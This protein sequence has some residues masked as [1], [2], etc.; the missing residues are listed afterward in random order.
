MMDDGEVFDTTAAELHA[1]ELELE[2]SKRPQKRNRT[3]EAA[4]GAG[5]ADDGGEGVYADVDAAVDSW[6]VRRVPRKLCRRGACDT[7]RLCFAPVC[8]QNKGVWRERER[9]RGCLPLFFTRGCDRAK[10]LRGY[11]FRLPPTLPPTSVCCSWSRQRPELPALNPV[12]DSIAFQWLN[13]DVCGGEPLKANPAPGRGIAGS[14]NG[15]VPILHLFGVTGAGNS[16]LCRVHGFTP[17]MYFQPPTGFTRDHLPGLKAAL[18]H[19]VE[20][21]EEYELRALP[22]SCLCSPSHAGRGLQL[23][24]RG[25]IAVC[26]V[27]EGRGAPL[28]G[29]C[30]GRGGWVS[31]PSRCGYFWRA[32]ECSL[33]FLPGACCRGTTTPRWRACAPR[34]GNVGPVF[35]VNGARLLPTSTTKACVCVWALG[36]A[37]E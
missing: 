11:F 25:Y 17:Y 27:A 35:C 28:R 16:V 2:E 3:G 26:V 19:Q 30:N 21:T 22:T 10:A 31:P 4:A 34:F 8:T 37:D 12:E 5:S 14:R 6:R 24:R 13:I 29:C 18:E 23:C 32:C 1:A 15:P 36:S 7:C 33:F 20:I 9:G